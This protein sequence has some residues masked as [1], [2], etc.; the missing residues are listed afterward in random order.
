MS[1]KSVRNGRRK[2][3]ANFAN[4]LATSLFT[5]GGL[6]QAATMVQNLSASPQLT[7]FVVICI[8]AAVA[9]HWIA[10]ALLG[11]LEE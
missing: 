1:N 5:V 4:G 8:L 3:S 6:A 7:T 11:G 10:R 9:L 2:I